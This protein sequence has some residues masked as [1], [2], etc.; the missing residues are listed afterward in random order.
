M[1]L[2]S[3]EIHNFK[4][5]KA[6]GPIQ[7]GPMNVLIGANGSGK[8]N[9]ISFF[10]LLKKIHEGNLQF[11]VARN[12]RAD[13]FLHFGAKN[14]D[15]VAGEVISDNQTEMY[16]FQLIPDDNGNL[17]F[18]DG[19]YLTRKSLNDKWRGMKVNNPNPTPEGRIVLSN[20]LRKNGNKRSTLDVFDFSIYHFND[21]SFNSNIKKPPNTIDYAYLHEDGGNLAAFLYR[22]SR[23]HKTNF[24]LIE[25]VVRSIAPFFD[26]FY[27]EPDETNP[28]QIFLRWFEKGHDS[29]W[30]AHRLSDGTLR[31]IA[32]ATALFQPN[33]PGTIIIDEPEMG[34]HP[35]AINKLAAMLKSA[36]AK[37]QIIVATQSINLVSEF[38]AN[39]IIIVERERN[40][41]PLLIQTTFKRQSEK[42]LEDWLED[43]S[44]G[45]LWEKNVI[46][47]RP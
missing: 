34:L 38:L 37:T 6:S 46:G 17:L 13:A 29:M 39:D 16:Q 40:G 8:S 35:F 19:G 43:Y 24:K 5:I 7:L 25:R 28:D 4:S 47:G 32:L 42:E 10:K 36:S 41:N 27:L 31:F 1:G 30:N 20:D 12:G 21:T 18:N 22:L 9:F 26:R 3:V 15:F 2:H 33:P 11:H 14:S 45:E 44:L 23:S